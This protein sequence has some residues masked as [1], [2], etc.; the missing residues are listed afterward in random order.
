MNNAGPFEKRSRSFYLPLF[1]LFFITYAYFF[2]GG[3]WN[4]NARLCLT[5]SLIDYGTFAID[6]CRE[7][8]PGMGWVNTGDWAYYDGHYY[9][10]KS[11][12][13]SFLAVPFFAAARGTLTRFIPGDPGRQVLLSAYA[14]TVCTVGALS[15]LL[16][17]LIFSVFHRVFSM[18]ATAAM[19][20]TVL[21]GF[22]TLAF[23]YST[24]FY[25]H[26]PAA[27]CSLL[28][29][30]LAM[31]IRYGASLRK[32]MMAMLAGF[33]A[34]L[35]VLIE[36]STMIM[37]AVIAF[38]LVSV[39]EGRS[40]IPLFVLGCVLPG[41][42][43]GWYNYACFGHPLA[44]SYNYS[45]DLVMW[46]VEGTLFGLPD[47]RR[48]YELLISPYRGLLFS[49]PVLLMAVPGILISLGRRQWR[50]ALLFCALISGVFIL[51]IAGF[52]AWHG[53]SAAGPRYLLPMFPFLYLI[54]G[55]SFAR[56]PK[57]FLLL[58]A[59]S[60]LIN[61][62]IT[63]VG[64]E[65]PRDNRNPLVDVVARN[66]LAGKVSINPVP[67][68]HF[69]QYDINKLA[70]IKQWD[71]LTNDN[72]FNLG[73]LLFPHSLLSLAPLLIFFA[74]WGWWWRRITAQHG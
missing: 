36:P 30:V 65:I 5:R 13:L 44:S 64:N 26:Q 20:L 62:S 6:R 14:S 63:V 35:A 7:D 28:A 22:G 10:N 67:V 38:C 73:E 53:G 15:A 33:S 60:L 43:L 48:F 51:F 8:A 18:S 49:S 23:S 61:L 17:L 9:S 74:A 11:P 68:A 71:S 56:F 59:A 27:C 46:K 37:L 4:Q 70:D 16:C 45:N 40:Y 39:R 52:H 19:A 32:N 12:G 50:S 24:T 55:M 31:D 42:V 41:A 3:G 34:A 72:S 54:A 57:L 58:G 2:Q 66:L 47:V 21:F 69:E 1:L 29:F 25:C